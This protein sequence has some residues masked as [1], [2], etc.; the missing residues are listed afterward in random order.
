MILIPI[1]EVI[2]LEEAE[3]G[4]FGILR[5]Q[6]EVKFWTL[7]PP[8]FENEVRISSIPAQQY[9]IER[10]RSNNFGETFKI[11]NVPGRK[12]VLFHW[13]NWSSNTEGCILLG[14]GL[15]DN[16]RGISNSRTAFDKFMSLLQGH[17]QAHLT[18]MEVF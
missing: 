10:Y 2:R 4:T 8:D 15:M 6:K 9:I 13:G 12:D 5:I 17:S 11:R 16:P 18:I 7:E 3:I 1:I 14:S